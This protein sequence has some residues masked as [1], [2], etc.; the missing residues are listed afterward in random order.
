MQ[1]KMLF[2]AVVRSSGRVQIERYETEKTPYNQH[3]FI[4]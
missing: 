1:D 2:T 4:R 3:A